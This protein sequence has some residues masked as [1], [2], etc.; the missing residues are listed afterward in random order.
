MILILLMLLGAL[1]KKNETHG[2]TSSSAAS[3]FAFAIAASSTPVAS[4]AEAFVTSSAWPEPS[5]TEVARITQMYARPGR[6]HMP[7]P[8]SSDVVL[9]HYAKAT[10]KYAAYCKLCRMWFDWPLPVGNTKVKY[11]MPCPHAK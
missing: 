5:E 10:N 3:S 7:L 4:A 11:G 6:E 1:Q 8:P 9:G 2:S